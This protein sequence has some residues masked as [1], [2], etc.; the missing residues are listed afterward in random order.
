MRHLVRCVYNWTDLG[1]W[2]VHTLAHRQFDDGCEFCWYRRCHREGIGQTSHGN[3]RDFGFVRAWS[4]IRTTLGSFMKLFRP[5]PCLLNRNALISFPET[6][7][8]GPPTE[9]AGARQALPLDR[10]YHSGR[11]GRQHLIFPGFFKGDRTVPGLESLGEE[12]KRTCHDFEETLR[13]LDSAGVRP[14]VALM[15]MSS[16]LGGMLRVN[17]KRDQAVRIADCA[18]REA[19]RAPL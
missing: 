6:Q 9:S 2:A 13:M 10:A 1:E 7:T 17:Y 19:H 5:A 15:G 4:H 8:T 3:E 16:V 11:I 12:L 18:S 14:I